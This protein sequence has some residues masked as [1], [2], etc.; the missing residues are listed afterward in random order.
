MRTVLIA[1]SRNPDQA[2]IPAQSQ[3][4][5]QANRSEL[6]FRLA[7][8]PARTSNPWAVTD[9][10]VNIQSRAGFVGYH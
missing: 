7:Q 1:A 9:S 8:D 10:G 3:M 5:A 4:Y 6:S 2:N